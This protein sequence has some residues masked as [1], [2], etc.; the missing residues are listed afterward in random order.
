MFFGLWLA[1]K[2]K[3]QNYNFGWKYDLMLSFGILFVMLFIIGIFFGIGY[4]IY[5]IF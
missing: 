4:L 1:E 3:N 2:T 5:K